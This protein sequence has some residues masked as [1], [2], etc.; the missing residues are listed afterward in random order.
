M[1]TNSLTRSSVLLWSRTLLALLISAAWL[2]IFASSAHA[3]SALP[4]IMPEQ[5]EVSAA[6]EGCHHT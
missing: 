3:A 6:L 2:A 1:V 5:E 4:Q